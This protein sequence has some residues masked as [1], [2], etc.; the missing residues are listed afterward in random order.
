MKPIKETRFSSLYFRKR[1][2]ISWRSK[3]IPQ[4]ILD[5]IPDISSVIDF[6]CAT[7]DLLLGF[8]N[9]GIEIYGIDLFSPDYP[10]HL[11]IPE[12]NISKL[13][14]SKQI[15]FRQIPRRCYDLAMCIETM[16]YF[17]NNGR[18][19]VVR[20][21]LKFSDTI[22]LCAGQYRKEMIEI[23]KDFNLIELV[24]VNNKIKAGLEPYKSKLAVRALY[25]FVMVWQ[26]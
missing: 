12:E 11:L 21:L 15:Y 24:E 16:G 23:C 3:I 13:D 8:R 19:A 20:N 17:D 7:G 26:K 10:N 2:Y 5:A 6:A 4:I 22:M 14:I 25:D 18:R 1:N 9:L